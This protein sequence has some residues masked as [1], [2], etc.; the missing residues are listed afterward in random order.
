MVDLLEGT[1][2]SMNLMKVH[3]YVHK[4]A[5]QMNTLEEVRAELYPGARLGQHWG[6]RAMSEGA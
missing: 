3:A 6:P 2:Y 1:L 5:S 4:V